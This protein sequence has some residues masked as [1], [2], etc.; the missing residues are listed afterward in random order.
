MCSLTNGS[1]GIFKAG[2]EKDKMQNSA[3]GSK[4]V[5]VP[6]QIKTHFSASPS[7]PKR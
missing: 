1:K 7:N 2:T 6:S 4:L 5:L 3:A